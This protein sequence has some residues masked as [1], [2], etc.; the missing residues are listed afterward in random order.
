M[1]N[2]KRN[3]LILELINLAQFSPDQAENYVNELPNDA[4]FLLKKIKRQ[5]YNSR[6][7]IEQ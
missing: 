3:N 1:T 2:K 5:I 7:I 4:I 6:K